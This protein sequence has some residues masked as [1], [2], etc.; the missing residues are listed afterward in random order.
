VRVAGFCCNGGF[1]CL[2]RPVAVDELPTGALRGTGRWTSRVDE[3]PRVSL[4]RV[5]VASVS[6]PAPAMPASFPRSL[7]RLSFSSPRLVFPSGFS[8]RTSEDAGRLADV[9][10]GATGAGIPSPRVATAPCCGIALSKRFSSVS[11]RN[12]CGSECHC[13]RS[14]RRILSEYLG[15]I[16]SRTS[17]NPATSFMKRLVKQSTISEACRFLLGASRSSCHPLAGRSE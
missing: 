11:S 17:L 5:L 2:V 7:A 16:R 1:I 6:L 12:S 3:R 10:A 8:V 15:G 9:L 14:S 4:G 13:S